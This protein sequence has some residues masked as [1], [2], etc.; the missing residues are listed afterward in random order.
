MGLWRDWRVVFRHWFVAR[1]NGM[2][3][4]PKTSINVQPRTYRT[5]TWAK[6]GKAAASALFSASGGSD[7]HPYRAAS[8][9][10]WSTEPGRICLS[11]GICNRILVASG[12][13]LMVDC[14]HA[15]PACS[16]VSYAYC[17]LS[18]TR[19]RWAGRCATQRLRNSS[20]SPSLVWGPVG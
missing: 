2:F 19:R 12:S 14:S 4:P 8:T 11:L 3:L 17:S 5:T 1:Q 13:G 9:G 18:W 10:R 6:H 15:R 7:G 16:I 20:A